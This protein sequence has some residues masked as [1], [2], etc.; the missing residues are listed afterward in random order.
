[1][2]I[3]QLRL[4]NQPLTGNKDVLAQRLLCFENNLS[5]NPAAGPPQLPLARTLITDDA[6]LDYD[7]DEEDG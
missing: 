4:F 6:Q 7:S 1:M 2:W 5:T 3:E